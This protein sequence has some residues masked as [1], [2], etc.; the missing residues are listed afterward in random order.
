MIH[1]N[2]IFHCIVTL[3]VYLFIVWFIVIVF[4]MYFNCLTRDRLPDVLGASQFPPFLWRFWM[5]PPCQINTQSINFQNKITFMP[6]HLLVQAW[7]PDLKPNQ[8]LWSVVQT[9]VCEA[10]HIPTAALG[11]SS[12]L[13]SSRKCHKSRSFMLRS[14]RALVLKCTLTCWDA[15]AV[16]KFD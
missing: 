11:A 10:V 8:N 1:C 7:G 12:D 6:D 4:Y 15:S 16:I 2:C 5:Y 13:L 9:K 14:C 3:T